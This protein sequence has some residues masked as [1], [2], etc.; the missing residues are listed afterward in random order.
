MPLVSPLDAFPLAE[1]PLFSVAVAVA[2]AQPVFGTEVPAFV[3]WKSQEAPATSD[4][5]T[6]Q[7]QQQQ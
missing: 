6:Q 5:G 2:H 4:A 1:V 3:P 7:Q